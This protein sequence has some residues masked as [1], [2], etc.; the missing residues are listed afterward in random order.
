MKAADTTKYL[1]E[2]SALVEG[3]EALKLAPVLVGGMAL[4]V[5][6]SQRVTQDFDFVIS[7]PQEKLAEIV[8]LF[9]G[10]GL[11]LVSKLNE[12]GEVIRT[13]D[14][15]KVAEVRLRLDRP[16]SAYFY[17]PRTRLKV[18]LLFDFPLKAAELALHV[19]RIKVSS[20]SIPMASTN[21]LLRLKKIAKSHRSKPGDAED[22]VFLK[23][24][25]KN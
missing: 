13:I 3:L 23:K 20:H 6:G 22:L 24:L 10:R 4:V 21:D 16:N 1:K 18:D 8:A 15:Q 5:L 25:C 19:H 11:E 12:T 17:H 7:Q 2:I 9:Y 14:N